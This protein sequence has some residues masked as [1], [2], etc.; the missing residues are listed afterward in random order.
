MNTPKRQFPWKILFLSLAAVI[1]VGWIWYAAIRSAK[2]TPVPGQS[3]SSDSGNS[4]ADSA[5]SEN[6]TQADSEIAASHDGSS[7]AGNDSAPDASSSS[8]SSS[9]SESKPSSEPEPVPEEAAALLPS[10]IRI[11]LSQIP[12][13]GGEP[14]YELNR[15]IPF[16]TEEDF[17]AESF[18][19]YGELDELGRCTYAFACVGTDLMPTEKRER[20]S[21]IRPSGWQITKY[22][23]IDGNFLYN[24][25]HLIAYG[26]TAENANERNL[27]TGTRYMNTA[28]MNDLENETISYIRRTNN[29][30]LY[31]VTPV[32]E[33]DNLVASGVI[34]EA[35]SVEKK[36]FHFC[37]YAYNVQPGITID[38]KTGESKGKPFTGTEIDH[39]TATPSPKPD[40]DFVP[41]AED[42][43]YVLN[44]HSMKFHLPDCESVME[45]N[46]KNREDF[47]GTREELIEKGYSPCGACK[48]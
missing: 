21:E 27:I 28:G 20:I 26:L 7:S 10:G 31:R 33:G 6:S 44:T 13:Y 17:T 1:A 15:N 2:N 16:F 37:V 30:V 43:T 24:R 47:K 22:D 19:T 8:D 18:E 9:A 29:H 3:I 40:W 32:F 39:P 4:G 38:Y 12:P 14:N 11:D 41:P 23:G 45:M 25:C 48:P 5:N 42:V 35:Q 36:N 34:M 46:P